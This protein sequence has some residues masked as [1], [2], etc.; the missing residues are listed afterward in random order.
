M[1]NRITAGLLLSCCAC[2][3]YSPIS[4]TPATMSQDVR[5]TMT[6]TGMATS[7]GSMGSGIASMEGRLRSVT[8][9]TLSLSVTSLTRS[10]GGDEA[11][12]NED[13]TLSRSNIA[14]V[15]HRQ[16]SVARS[17]LV[18]GAVVAGSILVARAIGNGDQ[19]GGRGNQPQPVQ[20]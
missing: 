12:A 7:Y 16:T 2:Q 11:R 3:A 9:S 17:L 5:V 10:D 13:V 20:K 19:T 14:S 18:A 1:R 4:V 6:N 8:D 15:E